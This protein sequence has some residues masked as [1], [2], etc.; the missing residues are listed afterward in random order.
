MHHIVEQALTPISLVLQLPQALKRLITNLQRIRPTDPSKCVDFSVHGD[1]G[2][3]VAGGGSNRA[4]L[5]EAQQKGELPAALPAAPHM[6]AADG[7]VK[8]PPK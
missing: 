3:G 8:I 4:A 2:R 7:S 6:L 5:L 1:E